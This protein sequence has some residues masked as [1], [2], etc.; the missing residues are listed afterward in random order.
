[1]NRIWTEQ[2]R[3]GEGRGGKGREGEGRGGKG[4]E[5]GGKGDG[6]RWEAG[7]KW[8][9]RGMGRKESIWHAPMHSVFPTLLEAYSILQGYS[10]ALT[11]LVP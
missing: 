4:R 11:C 10:I 9:E 1:L 2:G 7:R 8:E 3:E 5:G 6:Q